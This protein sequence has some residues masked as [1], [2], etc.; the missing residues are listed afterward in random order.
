MFIFYYL[1]PVM[2]SVS[3]VNQH[4][5]VE[6]E[7]KAN[8]KKRGNSKNHNQENNSKNLNNKQDKI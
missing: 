8:K 2:V 6:T 1:P 4:A 7:V 5:E 3:C